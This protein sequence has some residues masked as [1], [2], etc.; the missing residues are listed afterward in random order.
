MF[1]FQQKTTPW[2]KPGGQWKPEPY[3]PQ[4]HTHVFIDK[5]AWLDRI[6]FAEPNAKL[7][8]KKDAFVLT[9]GKQNMQVSISKN[10][11]SAVQ[12]K[13]LRAAKSPKSGNL[14]PNL[15]AG[16]QQF[17][18]I[19]SMIPE[20]G[21]NVWGMGKRTF[22][23]L[24]LRI[25]KEVSEHIPEGAIK[26][27]AINICISDLA[28]S[29]EN[30]ARVLLHEASHWLYDVNSKTR[31]ERPGPDNGMNGVYSGFFQ[32]RE[33]HLL[34]P[35]D[36][37]I[38]SM[39]ED[40][41]TYSNEHSQAPLFAMFDE[42]TYQGFGSFAGHPYDNP[43]ELFASATSV[44][45]NY[46]QEFFSN[47]AKLHA[48]SPEA[49][50]LV[51]MVADAVCETHEKSGTAGVFPPAY[52]ELRKRF[53]G[54]LKLA[55]NSEKFGKLSDAL[56]NYYGFSLGRNV[57]GNDGFF[58]AIN[59]GTYAKHSPLV[60]D[61]YNADPRRSL[62]WECYSLAG[63]LL[64]HH[65]KEFKSHIKSVKSKDAQETLKQLMNAVESTTDFTEIAPRIYKK[66]K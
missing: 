2:E 18:T 66:A 8:E 26:N 17:E 53:A 65:G 13:E 59:P 52:L 27:K 19:Y 35:Q 61:E 32:L 45:V 39:P 11:L 51:L 1:L 44:L 41:G 14:L 24:E 20:T 43:S 15:V 25:T 12:I 40:Q 62:V 10:A 30:F 7:V 31:T 48:K 60:L 6:C 22:K 49:A 38:F 33:S 29:P 5:N 16:L 23:P 63:H 28:D 34:A 21:G 36:L 55:S 57:P 4:D 54:Y 46:P 47:L 37:A 9:Y 42:S 64:Q 56:D 50:A 58:Q 3:N